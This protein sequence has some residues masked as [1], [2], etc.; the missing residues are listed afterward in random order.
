MDIHHII[1]SHN[2]VIFIKGESDN[3]QCS[4]SQRIISIFNKLNVKYYTVNVLNDNKIKEQLKAY[5]RWPTIPQVYINGNFIGG[6][7][8]II[9]LYNDKKLQEILEIL[10]NS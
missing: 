2:I 8:I 6:T 4:F 1:H 3:P 9:E 10:L 7:D 5:S